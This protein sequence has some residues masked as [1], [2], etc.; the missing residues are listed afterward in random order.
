MPM[1]PQLDSS[2]V[3]LQLDKGQ[4][5]DQ[6]KK[7]R[8][9]DDEDTV[10]ATSNM[11]VSMSQ[12]ADALSYG[13]TLESGLDDKLNDAFVIELQKDLDRKS[14]QLDIAELKIQGLA[15]EV[16]KLGKELEMSRK[17]LDES[18]MNCAH[19]ENSLHQARKEA[20]TN[21]CAA[22]RKASEYSTLRIAAVK[23]HGHFERLKNCVLLAGLANFSEYLQDLA[24]SIGS[25][26]D[27]SE[28]DGTTEFRE[29]LLMLADKVG[30]LSRQRAELLDRHS[31]TEAANEQLSKELAEKSELVNTLSFRHQ[32]EKKQGNKEKISFGRLEVHEIAAFILN[33]T[34]FYEAINRN[35]SYYFLSSESLAL[36][37]DNL[38]SRPNY[39]IGQIVHIERRTAKSAPSSTSER[40]GD[41]KDRVDILM[42]E[43]GTKQL[44][45]T[46]EITQLENPYGLTVG[47][48]YLLVTIAML[49][50]TTIHSPLS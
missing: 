2:M 1:N 6:D 35:N 37:T 28:D 25:V 30:V 16:S 12:P 33:S 10:L 13:T 46:S 7:G 5:F 27:G 21:L 43:V 39:I 11:A 38:T 9:V 8:L 17:L 24:Q 26:A 19:L 47:C 50:D 18:Q 40:A 20:Q 45:L 31:K 15:D 22:D 32:L 42:S 48:E 29:C 49:P 4:T 14:S 3:D 41:T 36:F 34:G 44:T 23:M